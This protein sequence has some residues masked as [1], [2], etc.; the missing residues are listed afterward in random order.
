M[1]FQG[2]TGVAKTLAAAVASLWVVGCAGTPIVPPDLQENIERHVSF[3][4]VKA[5]PLSYQGKILV[6]GGTVLSV[7]LLKEG[8]TR[9]EIL[10][11]PHSSD[12]E[13]HGP[14]TK[15]GGR[16]LALHKA[17][18]DPATIP[19]GTRVTV[20]GKVIGS[21]TAILDEFEYA[22]PTFDVL[23][24]TMWPPSLPTYW[25]RPYPYF[26]IYWGP[27]WGSYWGPPQWSPYGGPGRR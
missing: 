20:V 12:Y 13:P 2:K 19:I 10:Q 14:L 11:L 25:V 26:G 15:S 23:S 22:Y 17:F 7:K 18:L 21:T 8:G 27:Y 16:F 3:Q 4:Q 24:L 9:I 5:S 1:V 6:V